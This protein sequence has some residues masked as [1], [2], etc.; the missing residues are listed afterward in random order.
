MTIGPGKGDGSNSGVN[1]NKPRE[2]KPNA[3]VFSMTQEEAD[4]ANDVVTGTIFIQQVHAYVLFDYTHSF[5][6]KIFAKKLGCKPENLTEPFWIATPTSRAIETREIYRDCK[7]S[8][9]NQTFSVDL[10]QLIMVDFDIIL[11][12]DWLARNSAIVA[13]KEKR[14][15]LRTPDQEE[16]VFMVNPRSGS[17][18]FPPLKL[19]KP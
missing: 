3:K 1:A 7:I 16:I 18:C 2:N 10:I 9:G 13:C 8:I 15:K 19:G 5:M 6:S 17:H 11:G 14:I 12:M 4:D